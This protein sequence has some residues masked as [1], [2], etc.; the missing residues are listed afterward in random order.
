[1][2]SAM[3]VVYCARVRL[4][5]RW[6]MRTVKSSASCH[7]DVSRGQAL[8]EKRTDGG[9]GGMRERRRGWGRALRGR[10]DR[11]RGDARTYRI[12]DMY[13]QERDATVSPPEN[14]STTTSSSSVRE[15][16]GWQIVAFYDRSRRSSS[17][18]MNVKLSGR[19]RHLGE[20]W[21]PVRQEPQRV[22]HGRVHPRLFRRTSAAPRAQGLSHNEP[23][24]QGN[25]SRWRWSR[26]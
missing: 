24:S 7:V 6:S 15:R 4:T 19:I 8:Y 20:H 16:K 11:A 26:D 22:P 18:H 23:R 12:G 21:I 25:L 10:I 3:M 9:G 2:I 1:M 14:G 13:Q 17:A 5:S